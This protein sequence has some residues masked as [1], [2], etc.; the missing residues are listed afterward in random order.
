MSISPIGI[1]D[2]GL[3]GLSVFKEII[4]LLPNENIVYV[5]DS[6]NCPYGEK[7]PEE[8]TNLSSRIVDFLI[9]KK[10]K[11]IVIA[12]NTATSASINYLR[13]N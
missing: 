11:I 1:F 4:K 13:K 8:I 12:C 3:G 2:S 9:Q 10:C 5:A 7:S 6:G